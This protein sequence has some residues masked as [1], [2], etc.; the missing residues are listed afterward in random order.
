[1]FIALSYSRPNPINILTQYLRKDCLNR[2]T[3]VIKAKYVIF[4]STEK[5]T[6]YS[7]SIAKKL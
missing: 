2:L 5:T 3:D 6:F 7:K 1:M 4:F